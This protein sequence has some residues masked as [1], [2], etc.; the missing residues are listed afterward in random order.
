MKAII[1]GIVI[2]V[3]IIIVVAYSDYIAWF[4]RLLKYKANHD[5]Q[6]NKLVN[7]NRIKRLVSNKDIKQYLRMVDENIKMLN[8][9]VKKEEYMLSDNLER[10]LRYSRYDDKAVRELFSDICKYMSVDE[11]KVNLHIRRTSSKSQT[12]SAGLYNE[13]NGNIVLEISTYTVTDQIIATLAHEL[14][15]HIMLLNGIK[16]EK[17]STNEV[18]TDLTAIYMGF[19]KYFY[20]SY[21]ERSRIIFDGE[22]RI[23]VDRKKLGYISYKDVKYAKKVLKKIK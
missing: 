11:S 19:Y 17:R 20:R 5:S 1:I 16:M 21:K 4:F 6:I 9:P 12:A 7:E 8:Y 15:H 13:E 2:I 23:L 22:S 14:S 18:Y 3:I 10:K